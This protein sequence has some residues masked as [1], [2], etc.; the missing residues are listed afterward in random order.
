M[1]GSEHT[2][3][4]VPSPLP[5]IVSRTAHGVT[6]SEI[7]VQEPR[8]TAALCACHEFPDASIDALSG[9]RF[10]DFSDAQTHVVAMLYY[11]SYLAEPSTATDSNRLGAVKGLQSHISDRSSS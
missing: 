4:L 9:M 6:R 10:Q 8:T 3:L 5:A 11:P 7:A 2:G 1:I